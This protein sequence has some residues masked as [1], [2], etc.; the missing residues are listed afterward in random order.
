LAVAVVF[1]ALAAFTR[2]AHGAHFLSD[3]VISALIV[4]ATAMVIRDLLKL[5]G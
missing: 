3:V 2:M 5:K 1:T 4:W